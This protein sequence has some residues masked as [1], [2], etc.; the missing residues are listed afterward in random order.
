[1]STKELMST[2]ELMKTAETPAPAATQAVTGEEPP[3]MRADA[4]RSR[5][6]LIEAATAAFAEHGADAPLDDIARRA[7]VGI[8]TL[9]RHF[10]TRPDLQAAVYRTQVETV[11]KR[12]DE[13]IISVPPDQAFA[14]WLSALTGYL[15]TKRGLA[16]S[17]I[18]AYGRDSELVMGCWK[19]MRDTADHLLLHA[20]QAGVVR[21]DVTGEDVLRLMHGVVVAT[22]QCPDQTGRLLA[23]TFDGLRTRS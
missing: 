7:G 12:A 22:E 4:R 18:A 8:G 5:A 21:E 6:K 14:G 15:V 3:R 23:L 17:L 9:Y 16:Q 13:L 20:Q 1:M 11:C 19:A 10:P 2:A